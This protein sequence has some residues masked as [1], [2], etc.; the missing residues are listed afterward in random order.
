MNQKNLFELLG[1]PLKNYRWSWGSIRSDQVIFL[2]VWQHETKTING[3]EFQRIGYSFRRSQV[4]P[5]AGN[6]ERRRH[7]E[8]IEGGSQVYM[9]VCTALDGADGSRRI[10][11]F[12]QEFVWLGGELLIQG[13][14]VWLE[15]KEKVSIAKASAMSF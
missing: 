11:S 13:N 6:N 5:T 10:Q 2:R 14:D 15:Q 8:A 1:A 9:V 7:I 12:N 3:K 4:K